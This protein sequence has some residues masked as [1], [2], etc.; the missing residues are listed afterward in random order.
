MRNKISLLL[1][2][3]CTLCLMLLIQ[4]ADG[5]PKRKEKIHKYSDIAASLN[6]Y[7]D[8]T[9]TV[10][11]F[12]LDTDS[13]LSHADNSVYRHYKKAHVISPGYRQYVALDKKAVAKGVGSL[14]IGQ[15]LILKGK[16]EKR[17][18]WGAIM[19]VID[20][21]LVEPYYKIDPPYVKYA[22]TR[23][24]KQSALKDIAAS[25]SG[26][27]VFFNASF[28]GRGVIDA[29]VY[30][31]VALEKDDWILIGVEGEDQKTPILLH[32]GNK[33]A[34]SAL[35]SLSVSDDMVLYG[36]VVELGLVKKDMSLETRGRRWSGDGARDASG[37]V[38]DKMGIVVDIVET[39][40]KKAAVG[41]GIADGGD[42]DA[43]ENIGELH[44]IDRLHDL[45]RY[46]EA[47]SRYEAFAKKYSGAE[48]GRTAA[49]KAEAMRADDEIM[50]VVREKEA[51]KECTGLFNMA[52]SYMANEKPDKAREYLQQIVDDHPAT[53]YAK[54]AMED[55]ENLTP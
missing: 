35:E 53:I 25:S 43:G 46:T 10:S 5:A 6:M 51:E 30:K 17:T 23:K 33:K 12:L 3:A 31:P 28:G 9:I 36:R 4:T 19:F 37:S 14:N 40:G 32:R 8:K 13:G 21:K 49:E 11:M 1:C 27:E 2:L 24:Y 22:A 26:E 16:V 20:A 41:G 45:E 42:D 34:V 55:M 15:R 44:A 52:R 18:Y 38:D 54:K 50:S 7:E 39:G 48:V 47:L 29:N